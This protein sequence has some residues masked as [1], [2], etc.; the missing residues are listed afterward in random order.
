MSTSFKEHAAKNFVARKGCTITLSEAR[1]IHWSVIRCKERLAICPEA[2]LGQ[3]TINFD[4][5]VWKSL[6]NS[7]PKLY[8]VHLLE[9]YITQ[10]SVS[11]RVLCEK[12]RYDSCSPNGPLH[13]KPLAKGGKGKENLC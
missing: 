13:Q 1:G 12:K 8:C 9:V 7:L 3:A 6:E 10:E 5:Q 11:L 2:V 4:L